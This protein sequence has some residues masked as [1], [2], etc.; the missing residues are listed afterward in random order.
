MIFTSDKT[1]FFDCLAAISAIIFMAVLIVFSSVCAAGA[2]AGI[3][4]CTNVLIP[5]LFPFAA[6]V[7][8]IT[9]T[10]FI[11]CSKHKIIFVY[12]LSLLGGYP[13][14]A[15]LI[16]EL[17]SDGVLDSKSAENLLPF[18]V[19]A[20][21]AFIVLAIGDGILGSKETGIVLLVSHIAASCLLTLFFVRKEF[22]S[23][24]SGNT[25]DNKKFF[26]KFTESINIAS[27]STVSICAFVIFFSVINSA[28]AS[29]SGSVKLLKFLVYFFEITTAVG[30][31]NSI[32]LIS[33]LLG[34][35][36]L[37]VWMQVFSIR[38]PRVLSFIAVRMLHGAL[39]VVLT[40]I[41][42]SVIVRNGAFINTKT[43]I[44]FEYFSSDISLFLAMS[45]MVLLLGVSIVSKKYS[46][47]LLKDVV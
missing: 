4:L 18:C 3:R 40:A 11:R 42:E 43:N 39:S 31:T 1:R 16:D 41:I 12:L 13:I 32:Y 23:D 14:G 44:A 26:D 45:V 6:T 24:L 47:N 36:G 8:F 37:S 35:G 19:N 29:L 28:A 38:K 5:S 27:N 34:F 21:P 2:K 46:G 22:V 7:V 15:K 9:K 20:G 30:N 17:Y 25:T 10:R 33:F